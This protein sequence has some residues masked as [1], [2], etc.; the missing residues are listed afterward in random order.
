MGWGGAC[1]GSQWTRGRVG[2]LGP[3]VLG[4]CLTAVFIGILA[5]VGPALREFCVSRA[6]EGDHTPGQRQRQEKRDVWCVAHRARV[7][8]T[9][10]QV[11]VPRAAWFTSFLEVRPVGIP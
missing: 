8:V 10:A 5:A 1:W 6:R 3:T 11:S 7:E 4:Q 9:Q 2:G